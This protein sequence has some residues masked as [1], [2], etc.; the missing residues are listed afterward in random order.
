MAKQQPTEPQL[1]NGYYPL[2]LMDLECSAGI[3]AEQAKAMGA[4][5]R[6]IARLVNDSVVKDLCEHG[7][8][9]ADLQANDIDVTRERAEAAG[10]S[11]SGVRHA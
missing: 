3:T 4:L 6:C 9:Q 11:A 7:A 8:L 2:T 10:F 5:F 1:I